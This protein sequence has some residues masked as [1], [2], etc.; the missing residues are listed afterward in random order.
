M[1]PVR[2]DEP[3]TEAVLD[4]PAVSGRTQR[5]MLGLAGGLFVAGMLGSYL[6]LKDREMYTEF[7]TTAYYLE[8]VASYGS[9]AGVL[10]AASLLLGA[11]RRGGPRD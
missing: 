7:N 3:V 1:E 10:A 11:R 8:A 4:R 6:S 2:T 9:M 5:V